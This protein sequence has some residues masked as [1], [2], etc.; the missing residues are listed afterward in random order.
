MKGNVEIPKIGV[1]LKVSTKNIS[2]DKYE[3]PLYLDML[4][5]IIMGDSSLFKEKVRDKK[6]LNEFSIGWEHIDDISTLY[7]LASSN[8]PDDLISEII[9]EF[10]SINVDEESFN[11]IKKV[12][13]SR[14]IKTIDNIEEEADNLYYDILKYRKVMPNKIE[15]IKNMKFRILKDMIKKIDFSN[16][17]IVKME[18]E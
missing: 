4:S 15:I 6:I 14:E 13:I 1:G 12:W 5:T 3:L 16:Y 9:S 2:I 10:N 8:K 7:V 17:S 18:K 11:R